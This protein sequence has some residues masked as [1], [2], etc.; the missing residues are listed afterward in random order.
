MWLRITKSLIKF[1]NT[2]THYFYETSIIILKTKLNNFKRT[3]NINK[4]LLRKG[5]L[6][7]FIL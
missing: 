6:K 5:V 1:K 2:H 3:G 7:I 4:E